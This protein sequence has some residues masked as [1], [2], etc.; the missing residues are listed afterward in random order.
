MVDQQITL[1]T[2]FTGH[3]D[4]TFRKAVANLNA[5]LNRLHRASTTATAGVVAGTKKTGDEMD[6]FGKKISKVSGG[7]QRL[8]AAMKVTFAY[9]LA[10]KAISTVT[11]AL[12]G[13]TVAIFDYDQALKNLQAITTATDAETAAMGATIKQVASDSKYSMKEVADSAV[14]L[15]QAGFTAS[16]TILSLKA[17]VELSTATLSS[18]TKVADLLTTAVRAFG[19]DAYEAGRIVDIFASAVNKSK[20]TIDKL[21]TAFN[22]LGPIAKMSGLSLEETAVGA[23][24]LANAGLRAS[25]IGT[26]FR[27][28]LSRLVNPSQKLRLIFKATGA[29]ME[30]LN[31]ATA[32]FKDILGELEKILGKNVDAAVRSQRAFQMFGQR[33]AAVA[34]AFAQAGTIG[35]ETMMREVLRVG[36]AADMAATQTEGLSVMADRL[37]QKVGLLAISIG[38]GGIAGAFRL[39]L[40]VLQPVVDFL[41]LVASTMGGKFVVAVTALTTVF[42]LLRIS[43]KYIIVQLSAL[44][45]GYDIATV[46]TMI[47]ATHQNTL[48]VAMAATTAAARTLWTAIKMNPF[49]ALAAGVAVVITGLVTWGRHTK[50]QEENLKELIITSSAQIGNLVKYKE[51]LQDNTK[52]QQVHSSIMQR[53]IR[54]YPQ[55]AEVVD[56]TTGKFK[57]NGAALDSLTRKHKEISLLAVV[58]L[59]RSSSKRIQILK[60]EKEALEIN[61][62]MNSIIGDMIDNSKEFKK[63]NDQ[64][65]KDTE[66][67]SIYLRDIGEGLKMYGITSSSSIE[68]VT[69]ALVINLGV[70]TRYAEGYAKSIIGYYKAMEAAQKGAVTPIAKILSERIKYLLQLDIY[71]KK[72]KGESF[73]DLYKG[74]SLLRQGDFLTGLDKVQKKIEKMEEAAQNLGLT[75]SQVNAQTEYQYQQFYFT[76]KRV[77]GEKVK[78]M[79]ETFDKMEE[80]LLKFA[81]KEQEAERKRAAI[82][83]DTE[84]AKINLWEDKERRKKAL[85]MN[86]EVY[87]AT[88]AFIDEKYI[89]KRKQLYESITDTVGK[90]LDEREAKE[91][92]SVDKKYRRAREEASKE[93]ED[94]EEFYAFVRESLKKQ[95][96]D[97]LII[98][99]FYAEKRKDVIRKIIREEERDVEKTDKALIILNEAHAKHMYSVMDDLLRTGE[100]TAAEYV[101]ILNA[102]YIDDLLNAEEYNKKKVE[103]TG[104]WFES[105]TA[106]VERAKKASGGWLEFIGQIGRD[107][108]KQISSEFSTAFMS[109]IDG[110]KTAGEAFRDFAKS[111]INWLIKMIIQRIIFNAI[112]G[113]L[114][115]YPSEEISNISASGSL[116]PSP[117]QHGGW[118]NEPVIGTGVRTGKTYSIAEKRPEYVDSGRNM[119]QNI[120]LIVNNNTGVQTEATQEGPTFDGEAMVISLFLNAVEKNKMGARD[121]MKGLF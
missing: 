29:D 109:F 83:R 81:N 75:T 71:L 88:L 78:V 77:E 115:T 45:F 52:S 18:T 101:D 34:A 79:R 11:G 19:E 38:E 44:A 104:T 82:A 94:L 68:D 91:L 39:L 28:V 67:L 47:L 40:S 2:L 103:A 58:G 90:S 24:I 85:I 42:L 32:S 60:N 100:I 30:K 21:R 33:G 23:M 26:G 41:S 1:G 3:V 55:L 27:Q 48:T 12:S 95:E 69:K 110:T 63:I 43:L 53:L 74:L 37:R 56:T 93:I 107:I 105:F 114:T 15:G 98:I 16:E 62:L 54:E 66:D 50:Q 6:N 7:F 99:R 116:P 119:G 120:K 13:A 84:R 118:I 86:E 87:Q 31:P 59:A 111:V 9:G 76:F 121:K 57:D 106:G 80:D 70:S 17:V 20:L 36:T 35:F 51:K 46:K 49:L 73:A 65:G 25:T 112:S 92:A 108:S 96:E 117:R 102:A 4:D 89:E 97:K 14:V 72:H 22:Y 64:M 61:R 8:T 113:I 10:Y 5:L